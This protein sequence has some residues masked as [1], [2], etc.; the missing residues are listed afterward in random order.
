[1]V[2][3]NHP[4]A[5][6]AGIDILR[7]GGNAAD[8]AIAVNAMLSVVEPMSCGIG[9]DVS[10]IYWDSKTKKLYGLNGSGRS[11]QSLTQNVF[12]EQEL[13]TKNG[14]LH[15]ASEPRKDGGAVGY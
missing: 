11:P 6:Q 5:A 15:G 7:A 14:G 4:L 8:A 1:M 12:I 10:V 2:A 13:D 3:T 9:G